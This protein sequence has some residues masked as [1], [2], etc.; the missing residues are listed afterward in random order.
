MNNNVSEQM[1]DF[2]VE[3][4]V[5]RIY[6][7]V[8]DSLN[9]VTDAIHKNGK[10][11]WVHVRNEEAA[12]FAASAEAQITG[13][14]AVCC[15]SSGPG[16]LHLINGLFDAHHSHAPVL[17]IASHLPLSKVGTDYFQETHPQ[18]L[19]QECS[20]YVELISTPAQVT[21]VLKNAI[22]KAIANQDV[23]VIVLP[24]DVAGQKAEKSDG[25][26]ILPPPHPVITPA[27]HE[28]EALAE[29]LNK[30]SRITFFCGAGCAKANPEVVKLAGM[31]KAPIAYTFRGKEWMEHD[32]PYAI[33]MTGLLGWG[34][35]Y[36]AMHECDLLVLWGTDFPYS[37]FI[38]SKP[39]VVQVDIRADHLG[40]RCKLDLALCGDVKDTI[41]ALLPMIEEK[42]EDAHLHHSLKQQA[43]A[44]KK[45][46]AYIEGT[47]A[48]APIRPEY[49]TSVINEQA[50]TDAVFTVDT[51]TPDIWSARY[52]CAPKGRRI[53]GSFKHGS[54]ACALAMALGAQ[55]CSPGRQVIALCGDGGLS[56]LP[57]DMI[58][59]KHYNLP[60]K[61]LV[62]N[63]DCLDFIKIEMQAVGLVPR[64]ID[65]HNPHF[66][67]VAE[68]M[69]LY[70]QRIEKPE[71]VP[72]AVARWLAHPGPA[73]LDVVVDSNALALP[74]HITLDQAK[75]F[76]LSLAK[77]ALSGGMPDVWNTLAG[78]RKLL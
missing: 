44:L 35:A 55:M 65:L 52:L 12:A 67:N 25:S 69:G 24:G 38:P 19:F 63:N 33:G 42:T 78:N 14:L 11:Q 2:L 39:V 73:L 30:S 70:G 48:K 5:N 54:M 23:S 72:A 26:R 41:T 49:L 64:E 76:S 59:L 58:T 66:A 40:N 15:G 7:I 75:G 16:N 60:V 13:N 22:N 46:N 18:I 68:A 6:G 77:Q 3:S 51:G 32:N 56:M 27:P 17:G 36:R 61:I 62:Y 28:L 29:L 1:V 57:G 43:K 31:V 37:E 20:T 45:I 10:I 9:P 71:D 50:E 74:P 34:D 47:K 8:G 4:G 21:P 53:I